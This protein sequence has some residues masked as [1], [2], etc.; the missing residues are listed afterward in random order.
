LDMQT[1]KDLRAAETL[2]L[3]SQMAQKLFRIIYIH[4]TE[5]LSLE[6]MT[7]D[8]LSVQTFFEE[9]NSALSELSEAYES[10]DTVLAGDIAEYELA[11]RFLKLYSFLKNTC[12]ASPLVSIT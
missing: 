8:S 1:G 6:T 5:G 10:R 7:I 4:K 11:P 2:Q 9:F 3:F 12:Q